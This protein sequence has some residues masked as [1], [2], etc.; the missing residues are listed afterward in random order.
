MGGETEDATARAYKEHPSLDELASL[1]E[2]SAN[3]TRV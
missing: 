2:T 3:G 1:E